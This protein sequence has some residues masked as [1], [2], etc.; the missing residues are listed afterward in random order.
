MSSSFLEKVYDYIKA[1]ADGS[2]SGSSSSS[3]SDTSVS[4]TVTESITLP[5]MKLTDDQ[6]NTFEGTISGTYASSLTSKT[7]DFKVYAKVVAYGH[8][9]INPIFCVVEDLISTQI[10]YL[11]VKR[12]VYDGDY[13]LAVEPT[14]NVL[15]GLTIQSMTVE[16]TTNSPTDIESLSTSDYTGSSLVGTNY[17]YS[18]F[19]YDTST[20]TDKDS[21][22][23]T[24]LKIILYCQGI[25]ATVTS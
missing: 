4:K 10:T 2:S 17:Y 19:S 13:L 18:S 15:N 24:Y 6:I 11:Q 23:Y 16:G 7:Y 20:T 14:N 8:Y 12:I 25:T 9:I 1:N 5:F 22:T 21:Q 3:S